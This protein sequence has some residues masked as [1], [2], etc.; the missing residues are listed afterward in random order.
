MIRQIIQQLLEHQ[1]FV[2]SQS[3]SV[4]LQ[5]PLSIIENELRALDQRYP[6]LLTL[7]YNNDD[8]A[9]EIYVMIS[10]RG[11]ALARKLLR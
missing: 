5:Q 1:T 10:E 3:L 6:D 8:K 4:R 9:P 2:S 7:Q 11:E